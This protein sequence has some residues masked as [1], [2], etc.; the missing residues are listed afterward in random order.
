[1]SIFSYRARVFRSA[2]S[3]AFIMGIFVFPALS[4][5]AQ[6]LDRESIDCIGCHETAVSPEAPFL[7]CHEAGCG[8]EIGLD[9]AAVA[10]ADRTLAPPASLKDGIRLVDNRISC[11]TCHI[12]YSAENH[13]ALSARRALIP[14]IPDPMLSV[15][16]TASA[17]CL[18]C[19][20]K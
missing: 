16:N 19:H 18:A 14:E 15:D 3:T 4:A 5:R 1:M 10:A 20:L 7:I 13:E 12:P 17:L 11:V 9:Y 8:H 2:L 6:T